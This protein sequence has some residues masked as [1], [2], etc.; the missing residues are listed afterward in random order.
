MS[1]TGTEAGSSVVVGAVSAVAVIVLNWRGLVDTLQ[2]CASLAGATYRGMRVYV[3]EN[4]SGDDSAEVLS[5]E[6]PQFTHI[7]NV[8]NLGFTGGN[9]AAMDRAL[10]DGAEYVLLLNNDTE[11]A[12]DFVSQMVAAADADPTIGVVGARIYY[13][14]R[15]DE[16]WYG[17]GRIDLGGWPIA[18]H[19][20]EGKRDTGEAS[21]GETDFVTGCCMLLR[22]EMVRQVGMLDAAYGYYD[23]D[24]D[25]CLRAKA[26]GWRV[27]YEPRAKLW[28]KV[29]RSTARVGEAVLYYGWRNQVVLAR[30]NMDRIAARRVARVCWREAW[31][32]EAWFPREKAAVLQGA[33]HG[34]TGREGMLKNPGKSWF[35]GVLAHGQRVWWII[36]QRLG[37][38]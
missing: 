7:A 6:F 4:G 14:S 32:K 9:N 29:S 2:C 20:D 12:A 38:I 19:V 33:F 27:W 34:L 3:V 23:E 37:L 8:E 16:L 22:A 21:G 15:P 10:A 1:L 11:V 5:R 26:A 36:K 25:L 35:W 31:K 17:G 13:H 18:R 24:V 30:R 28:H